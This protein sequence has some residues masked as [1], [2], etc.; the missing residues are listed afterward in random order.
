MEN[1]REEVK[2]LKALKM[3]GIKEKIE[4]I[5]MEAGLKGLKQEV[6]Q[7]IEG[8]LDDEWDP[9]MH[10]TH[11]R[12]LYDENDFYGVEVRVSWRPQNLITWLY[13]RM[14]ISPNGLMR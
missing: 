13:F 3:R 11:M 10:D 5:E 2:R 12:K 8:G 7:E 1:R 14:M 9:A 6:L 4:K